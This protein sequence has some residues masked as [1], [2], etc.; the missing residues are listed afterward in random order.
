MFFSV[1]VPS[2]SQM[3]PMKMASNLYGLSAR[4]VGGESLL[5]IHTILTTIKERFEVRYFKFFNVFSF[6]THF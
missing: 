4:A 3:V 5:F 1:V 6:L 2:L